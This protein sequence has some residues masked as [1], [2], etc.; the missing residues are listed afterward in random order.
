[1]YFIFKI[2]LFL[3]QKLVSDDSK[4]SK[5]FLESPQLNSLYENKMWD[6][7]E[8]VL[9]NCKDGNNFDF[10]I[11]DPENCNSVNSKLYFINF[12]KLLN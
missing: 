5:S 10:K 12:T 1:L 3:S 2:R 6:M 11:L 8:I 7:I 4:I 9:N